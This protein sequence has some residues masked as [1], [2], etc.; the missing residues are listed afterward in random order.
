MTPRQSCAGQTLAKPLRK[1]VGLQLNLCPSWNFVQLN[2]VKR[3]R[4]NEGGK[5]LNQLSM[6]PLRVLT[7]VKDLF[8]QRRLFSFNWFFARIQVSNV[9]SKISKVDE[10]SVPFCTVSPSPIRLVNDECFQTIKRR[11]RTNR[12][13][14]TPSS[15]NYFIDYKDKDIARAF[16]RDDVKKLLMFS[17]S[18]NVS[19][20]VRSSNCLF[21]RN[22]V[23]W[24]FM[25][26]K[27]CTY[28]CSGRR[29]YW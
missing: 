13:N 25:K 26:A 14:I 3:L 2:Y 15:L 18:L 19:P 10:K 4:R 7:I 8:E 22:W 1:E 21:S 11:V 20:P 9:N 28:C 29:S 5:W 24:T 12:K 27:S 6:G 16:L 17:T 23:R